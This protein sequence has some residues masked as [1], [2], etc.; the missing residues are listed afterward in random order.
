MTLHFRDGRGTT[1]LRYR[2]RV[3]ITVL[4][5]A[6]KLYVV[7]RVRKY[8]KIVQVTPLRLRRKSLRPQAAQAHYL[9][10]RAS[11]IIWSEYIFLYIFVWKWLFSLWYLTPN[12]P[13][14]PK[15]V[16]QKS[17]WLHSSIKFANPGYGFRAGAKTM[18]HSTNI[19]KCEAIDMKRIFIVMQIK[20]IFTRKVLY[21]VLSFLKVR[22]LGTQIRISW[23]KVKRLKMM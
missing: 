23:K 17:H 20:L 18:Q 11:E 15:F 1:L 2:N 5:C 22:V 3:E 13:N 6:Q 7:C 14:T 12:T 4:M 10:V 16:K 9:W 8:A 19:A 21:L